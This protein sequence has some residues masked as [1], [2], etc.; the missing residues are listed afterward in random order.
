MS[1]KDIKSDD[2]QPLTE[3]LIKLVSGQYDVAM[4]PML[5]LPGLGIVHIDN[6]LNCASLTHLDLSN[7]ALASVA[8]IE[9][10][11]ATLK[12]LDV[13]NNA[14]SRLDPVGRLASLE[15]LKLH[16]NR[17]SSI[18]DLSVL[19]QCPALRSLTL[20]TK[21]GRDRNPMCVSL[22]NYNAV[23]MGR[24]PKLRCLDEHYF[25]KA[26]ANPQCI[27]AGGDDEIVLPASAPWVASAYF[28]HRGMTGP[29]PGAA[30][31]KQFNALLVE[32]KHVVANS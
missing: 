8:G 7:N 9:V 25:C 5:T 18:D 14:V 22:D 29:K 2:S 11:A 26:D 4:V 19:C 15:V 16:G 30:A 13:S 20:Q 27:D 3:A 24:L 31:E 1:W 17:V 21:D 23:V 6:L 32:C 10:V 12:H 28:D